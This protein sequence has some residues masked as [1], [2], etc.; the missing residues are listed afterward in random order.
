MLIGSP[1]AAAYGIFKVY[2][3]VVALAFD[4]IGKARLHATQSGRRMRAFRRHQRKND[5][6]MAAPL[7]ADCD[8]QSSEAAADHQNIGVNEFHKTTVL[9]PPGGSSRQSPLGPNSIAIANGWSLCS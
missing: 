7:R 6:I 5:G 1:V 3:L 8:P 2:V 9:I 4:H